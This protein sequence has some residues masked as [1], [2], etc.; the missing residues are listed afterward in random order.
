[1]CGCRTVA[2]CMFGVVLALGQSVVFSELVT[3]VALVNEAAGDQA[4]ATCAAFK[5]LASPPPVTATRGQERGT[6]RH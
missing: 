2:V 1:M 4:S 6:H 5:R 3:K